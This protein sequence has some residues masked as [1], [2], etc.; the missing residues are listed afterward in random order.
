MKLIRQSKSENHV[1]TSTIFVNPSQFAPTEDLDKYPRTIDA[2]IN[3]L[4]EAG[5]D[6]LLLPPV[7]EI[8]PSGIT[9]QVTQ[10]RGTFV[11]VLGHTV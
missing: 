11:E 8:Y 1:T 6:L 3:M 4:T 5:C 10:Q 7:H 2:D 9:T